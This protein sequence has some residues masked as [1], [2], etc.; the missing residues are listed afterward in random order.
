MI[1]SMRF[2]PLLALLL[3]VCWII[4]VQSKAEDSSDALVS[5]IGYPPVRA[6]STAQA[7]FMARRAALLDAYRNAL[8][9]KNDTD[10]ESD[11]YFQN[12]AGFLRNVRI[13]DEAYLDDGAVMLTVAVKNMHNLSSQ[14]PA[15]VSRPGIS[16]ATPRIVPGPTPITLDEWMEIIARLVRFDPPHRVAPEAAEEP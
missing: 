14:A 15:T 10:P 5:G 9:T 6:E 3:C 4:P 2:A 16:A 12:V 7:L 13:V 8:N 1:S 11:R